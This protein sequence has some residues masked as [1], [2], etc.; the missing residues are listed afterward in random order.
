M[1]DYVCDASSKVSGYRATPAADG[2]FTVDSE[3]HILGVELAAQFHSRVAK[4]E[5]FLTSIVSSPTEEDWS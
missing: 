1:M 3:S 4:P 5:S 2:L